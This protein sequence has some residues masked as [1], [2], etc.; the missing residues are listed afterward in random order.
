MSDKKSPFIVEI[1]ARTD[2]MNRT[3]QWK[4]GQRLAGG[5]NAAMSFLYMGS[6]IFLFRSPQGTKIVPIEML[7][8]VCLALVAYGVF[9]AFRAWNQ[10]KPNKIRPL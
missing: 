8:Y 2:R 7:P 3:K 5:I 1:A 6:G 9:R 4:T 10:L